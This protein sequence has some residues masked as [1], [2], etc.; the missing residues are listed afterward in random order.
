MP[1]HSSI[2]PSSS[3][4]ARNSEAMRGARRGFARKAQPGRRRRRRGLAQPPHVARQD[5][6]ARARRSA[7]RSRHLVPGA[8]A[9]GGPRPLWRRRAFGERR[10]R[11]RAHL[12][13]RMR[14]RRQRRHHQ[15]RHL[16]SDDREEASA[17]AGHR[18]A[19]QSSL[20]LHGRFRRRLPAAAGRDLSGR[21]P[22]R[23]HLLQPGAD[24]VARHPA[25]RDRDG[26]LHR[27]RRL[28]A[29]DVGREHH[30]AQP[31]HHLPRRPAAGEGRDRRGG[32]A[33]RSS[34]APTCIRGSRA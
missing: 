5:A 26:L 14:D 19:E 17:R 4:F 7:G 9:A 6:G 11:R 34:A 22:F 13:P 25:D 24:V 29:G 27:R 21:A 28:C 20:R 31:G 12:G 3:D 33:P 1:L 18:A 2:D 23:P 16:L 8:V 32:D 10:H 15:G 30:R